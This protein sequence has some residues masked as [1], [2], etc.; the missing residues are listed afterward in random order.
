MSTE[1][2]SPTQ[3]TF[4]GMVQARPGPLKTD[5]GRP[6]MN[7]RVRSGHRI[8]HGVLARHDPFSAWSFFVLNRTFQFVKS[9]FF[10]L[11]GRPTR[12]SP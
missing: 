6:G 9:T 7:M 1:P 2:E 12:L 11:T 3:N 8:K 10:V 5:S 4:F